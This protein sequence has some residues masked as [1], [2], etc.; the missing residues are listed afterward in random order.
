MGVDRA[1][2]PVQMSPKLQHWIELEVERF[3]VLAAAIQ[4]IQ[5]CKL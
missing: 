1:G 4:G 3:S 2:V 5:K